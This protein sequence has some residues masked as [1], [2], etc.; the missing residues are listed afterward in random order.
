MSYNGQMPAIEPSSNAN[1]DQPEFLQ[2]LVGMDHNFQNDGF[3]EG[4]VRRLI[5]LYSPWRSV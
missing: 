5:L 4:I 1:A 3:T 2:F